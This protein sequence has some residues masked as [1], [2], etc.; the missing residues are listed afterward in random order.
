MSAARAKG[1]RWESSIVTYLNEQ[2]FVMAERRALSGSL[3]KGD[4]T[5]I[6]GVVIEAKNTKTINLAQFL[7]EANAEALNAK[8]SVGIAWIKRRGKTSP[9]EGYVLMS[10][11]TFIELLTEWINK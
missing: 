5:G 8:A 3:D 9:A 4:V 7:D 1:T 6:P 2:G 11:E 10:G